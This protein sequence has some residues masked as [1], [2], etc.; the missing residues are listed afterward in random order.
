MPHSGIVSFGYPVECFLKISRCL[1]PP[2]A[3]HIPMSRL[4][5]L[6]RAVQSKTESQYRSREQK[7]HS[8]RVNAFGLY[9][10]MK[11][12]SSPALRYPNWFALSRQ[13]AYFDKSPI[14]IY[15]FSWLK[16]FNSAVKIHFSSSKTTKTSEYKER[17]WCKNIGQSRPWCSR[18]W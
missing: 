7:H 11:I 16:I 8:R 2:K 3:A 5:F 15:K 6:F 4:F 1:S 18:Y 10:G 17:M 12:F 9:T 14:M 13:P